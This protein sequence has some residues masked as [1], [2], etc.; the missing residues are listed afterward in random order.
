M[1]GKE[2]ILVERLWILECAGMSERIGAQRKEP[3]RTVLSIG[4]TSLNDRG[5]VGTRSDYLLER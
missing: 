3:P 2:T 4:R 1:Y 5:C